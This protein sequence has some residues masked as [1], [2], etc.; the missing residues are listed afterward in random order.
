MKDASENKPRLRLALKTYREAWRISPETVSL[1]LVSMFLFNVCFSFA[2]IWLNRSI[3]AAVTE[4][5]SVPAAVVCILSLFFIGFAHKLLNVLTKLLTEKVNLT[6]RIRDENNIIRKVERIRYD[7]LESP[8]FYDQFS[9]VS[10]SVSSSILQFSS[11]AHTVIVQIVNLVVCVV[12]LAEH[13]AWLGIALAFLE[14][15]Y[16]ALELKYYAFQGKL[17]R[18][19][20]SA[21]RKIKELKN[22]ILDK[23]TVIDTKLNDSSDFLIDKMNESYDVLY[24]S[25]SRKNRY[26]IL[27]N[28]WEDAYKHV[29]DAAVLLVYLTKVLRGSLTLADYTFITGIITKAAD[30]AEAPVSY[31]GILLDDL[32]YV[33]EYFDF[34][35]LPEEHTGREDVGDPAVPHEI[36]VKDFSFRYPNRS[37][38]ALTNIN[39][40]VKP[41]E[42][43]AIVGENGAGKTT[44]AKNLLGLYESYEGSLGMDGIDY[45][46]ISAAAI[47]DRF[48]V[49]MQ[50]YM[51]YPFT[52]KD[53]IV[54]SDPER[55]E[56]E[57]S[58]NIAMR[59]VDG[60]GILSRLPEGYDTVLSKETDEDGTDLSEGQ[61]QKVMLSR[62]LHRDR[63][64]II[65]DEPTASLDP[66]A[67]ETFYKNVIDNADGKTIIIITH[68]L[69]CT[70]SA[71]RVIVLSGGKI[72]EEGNHEELMKR[73]GRYAEMYRVQA[74]GYLSGN[75][76][77]PLCANAEGRE[78]GDK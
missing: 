21:K 32:N 26:R 19:D 25:H 11:D 28:T 38:N 5:Y 9:L 29:R 4:K 74:E 64:I 27:I 34:M 65:F 23:N 61:W 31:F 33:N 73:N 41:G 62:A 16:M 15:G 50:D 40:T 20:A 44:L 48:S 67:E 17:R 12:M 36:T 66:M 46:E 77:G 13:R 30:A 7:L 35:E 53:N 2:V 59:S 52:L 8:D 47:Y 71:D 14:M 10:H 69:A 37:E 18:K 68:R 56:T 78:D 55:E 57:G 3:V 43:L 51:K 54:I 60:E 58:L 76:E 49:V 6:F 42:I 39:L 72:V 22:I 45:R 75:A 70:A 24:Q 1:N 63:G